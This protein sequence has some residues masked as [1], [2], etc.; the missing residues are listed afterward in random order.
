MSLPRFQQAQRALLVYDHRLNT[1]MLA[2]REFIAQIV[3]RRLRT[4]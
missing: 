2:S 3:D 1:R 4:C